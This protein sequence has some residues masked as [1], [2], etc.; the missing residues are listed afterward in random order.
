[1]SLSYPGVVEQQHSEKETIYVF[2]N[3]K[4]G[5]CKPMARGPKVAR[6]LKFCGPRKGPGL[7]AGITVFERYCQG[8]IKE[9]VLL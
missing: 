6:E 8:R 9:S 4:T 2:Q 3:P 7:Q 5:V 1:M